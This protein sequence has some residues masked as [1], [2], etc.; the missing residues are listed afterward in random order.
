VIPFVVLMWQSDATARLALTQGLLAS[1]SDFGVGA[2]VTGGEAAFDARAEGP[3]DAY[4]V[5]ARG[6]YGRALNFSA[7]GESSAPA[8]NLSAQVGGD[9]SFQITPRLR[10]SLDTQNYLASRFGVRAVDEL[11]ARDPFID[12]NRL[13][14]TTGAGL[15]LHASTSRR[16]TFRASAGYTQA[17]A[18]AASAPEALGVDAHATRG[19]VALAYDLGP[20]DT[21]TPELRY[22]FTH[23]YHAIY[24]PLPGSTAGVQIER[25]PADIHA[26]TALVEETHAFGP[27]LLGGA[28]L[29]VTA[30]TPPP[31]LPT[32]GAIFAPEAR[33]S[34]RY[35]APRYRLHA[36]YGFEYTSLGP[37]VGFGNQHQGLFEISFRPVRGSRYRDLQIVGIG[38]AAFGSAPVALNP[39]QRGGSMPPRATTGTLNTT[40]VAAGGRID[41]P[42]R[43]GLSVLGAVDLQFLRG[44]FDP[45]PPGGSA[46]ARF[47]TVVTLGI[48]GVL[49]T[50]PERTVLRDPG[51]QEEEDRLRQ[52]GEMPPM[53]RSPRPAEDTPAQKAS[54]EEAAASPRP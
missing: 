1:I 11:A 43:R 3:R 16:S 29:G 52:R 17:G 6:L 4:G 38:R 9:V 13:E 18:L 41:Y 10:F 37:R 45:P 49:S 21:I 15:G 44:Q 30:A 20:N 12:G 5:Q 22:A 47:Q 27:R 34:L 28:S 26:V 7:Q 31:I 2:L 53:Q 14:Y 39:P 51:E 46:P 19:S 8:D 35:F 50:D 40:S 23:F 54:D 33:L 36:A 48:A 25:G 42:L 24:G 32:R